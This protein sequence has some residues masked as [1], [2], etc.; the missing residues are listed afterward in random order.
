[1]HSRRQF[2]SF[3]KPSPLLRCCF[4][5]HLSLASIHGSPIYFGC[6]YAPTLNFIF[7]PYY[8]VFLLSYTFFSRLS[9]TH[10]K[11]FSSFSSTECTRFL[12]F[13]LLLLLLLVLLLLSLF[14]CSRKEIRDTISHETRR[15]NNAH[16]RREMK[17]CKKGT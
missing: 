9:S 6:A 8:R 1:M 2:F 5:I 17:R 16:V 10:M 4:F 7:S 13:E 11:F 12:R 3:K 15:K 14:A